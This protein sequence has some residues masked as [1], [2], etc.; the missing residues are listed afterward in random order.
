MLL[1]QNDLG[2]MLNLVPSA[3]NALIATREIPYVTIIGGI[4]YFCPES[5]IAWGKTRP[6]I[7][8]AG[9]QRIAKYKTRFAAEAPHAARDLKEFG[10][11][12]AERKPPKRY[13][14]TVK[15]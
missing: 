15:K 9:T 5:V 6:N 4:M 7:N 2:E 3:V 10:T 1:T 11:R 8:T 13:Y 12:F 14:G